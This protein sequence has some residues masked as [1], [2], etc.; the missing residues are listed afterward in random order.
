M[1]VRCVM[2]RKTIRDSCLPAGLSHKDRTTYEDVYD[3]V[4]SI[5]IAGE[6]RTI[7]VGP[8]EPSRRAMHEPHDCAR[9]V[10]RDR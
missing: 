8:D 9:K 1:R 7:A 4:R 3:K 6:V 2:L 5:Q 10:Q